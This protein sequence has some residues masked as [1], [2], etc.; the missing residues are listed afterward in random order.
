MKQQHS[1]VLPGLAS[2]RTGA[3]R[4]LTKAREGSRTQ[5]RKAALKTYDLAERKGG[6]VSK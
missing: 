3:E 5:V 2:F 4:V 1:N 6:R